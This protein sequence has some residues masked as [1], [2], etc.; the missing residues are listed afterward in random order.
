VRDSLYTCRALSARYLSFAKY[1]LFY[2]ALSQKR[3]M[4]LIYFECEIDT[5]VLW[6]DKCVSSAGKIHIM[7][8]ESESAS[9]PC[10]ECDI[11]IGGATISR[12]LKIIGRFCRM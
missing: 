2:R 9:L 1:R 6:S 4:I 10:I 3:P 12:L 11:H 8:S 5:H 7:C